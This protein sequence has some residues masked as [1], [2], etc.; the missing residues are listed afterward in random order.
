LAQN[1][2]SNLTEI[3]PFEGSPNSFQH[4]KGGF[5]R[6]AGASRHDFV[7]RQHLLVVV[8][9]DHARK[10]VGVAAPGGAGRNQ[11][12]DLDGRRLLELSGRR[13]LREVVGGRRPRQRGDH[14]ARGGLNRGLAAEHAAMG[15]GLREHNENSGIHGAIE[16]AGARFGRGRVVLGFGFR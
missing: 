14:H 3:P 9:I 8:V 15:I 13:G 1:G 12:R 4:R 5:G 10:I 16:I 11:N 2:V 7:R 6:N